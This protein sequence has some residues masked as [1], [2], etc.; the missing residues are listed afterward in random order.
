MLLLC[1]CTANSFSIKSTVDPFTRVSW[2]GVS[3]GNSFFDL[4][5]TIN[6][7][8]YY[9]GNFFGENLWE[10]EVPDVPQNILTHF[11]GVWTGSGSD[12]YIKQKDDTNLSIMYHNI[13]YRNDPSELEW[14]EYEEILVIPIKKDE[15]RIEEAVILHGKFGSAE[16]IERVE[17][18]VLGRVRHEITDEN[19]ISKLV[20]FLSSFA[21]DE[22]YPVQDCERPSTV[23]IFYYKDRNLSISPVSYDY[24]S[25]VYD[26]NRYKIDID[27]TNELDRLLDSLPVT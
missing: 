16:K 14:D 6:E 23:F 22:L 20:R 4:Y 27:R 11:R 26:H 25:L 18:V 2:K 21:L 13:E 8:D 10:Y 24:S 9:V 17:C 1:A 15:I 7:V 12:F 3:Y 5:C 19:D